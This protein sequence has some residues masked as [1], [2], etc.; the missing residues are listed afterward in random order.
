VRK[1]RREKEKD[2]A[3]ARKR[4]EEENAAKAYA[5]FLDEFE[6]DDT[7]RRRAG[8]DFVKASSDSNAAYVY[9]AKNRPEP[10]VRSSA[11]SF[12]VSHSACISVACLFKRFPL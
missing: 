11:H 9:P 10:S 5:E 4:E 2:A 6:A 3:E 1:S 7:G 12:A 8:A